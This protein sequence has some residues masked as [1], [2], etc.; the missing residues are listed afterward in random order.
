[1]C[2]FKLIPH[3]FEVTP[4]DSRALFGDPTIFWVILLGIPLWSCGLYC[5][6]ITSLSYTMVLLYLSMFNQSFVYPTPCTLIFLLVFTWYIIIFTVLVLTFMF[7]L[8]MFGSLLFTTVIVL[9]LCGYW[10]FTSNAVLY[11]VSIFVW[12]RL[13]SFVAIIIIRHYSF[14][15]LFSIL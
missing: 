10:V 13:S 4:S 11:A 12:H 15:S 14:L 3:W 2:S 9:F 6:F 7:N 1:M 5:N 8:S